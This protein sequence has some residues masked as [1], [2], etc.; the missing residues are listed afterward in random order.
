VAAAAAHIP[1]GLLAQVDQAA[2][3]RGLQQPLWLHLEQQI[4]VVV[5]VVDFKAAVELITAAAQAALAL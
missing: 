3:G 5:A 4:L 1:Q 2:V